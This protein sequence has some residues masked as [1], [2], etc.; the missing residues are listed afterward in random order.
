MITIKTIP[1][2]ENALVTMLKSLPEDML[3][4]VFWKTFVHADTSPLSREEKNA[5]AQAREEYKKQ[6][7]VKWQNIR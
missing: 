2:A 1:V 4:T 6:Q 7:T 3:A 5:V